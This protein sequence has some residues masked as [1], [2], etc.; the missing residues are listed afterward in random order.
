[1]A[2]LIRGGTV[3][4]DGRSM[5]CDVRM[6]NSLITQVGEELPEAGCMVV[7]AQ[8][9]LVFPGFID[10]HTHLDM[11]T[12]A[13][14]TADDFGTGSRA[15]L[16]GGTTTI[17]DFATQEKDGDLIQ[18]LTKWHAKADGVSS[19]DYA[20][21]MAI[22]D[23][24]AQV[25]SQIAR[26]PRHGVTSFKL[27]MAYDNLRI[28][29]AELYQVLDE[30]KSIGGIAGAHCENG[31][32]VN[33][34]TAKLWEAG[35]LSPA[36]HP[37]SRPDVVEAEAVW[38][39]LHIARLADVPVHI[40]HLSTSEAL[41]AVR[42]AR[43]CGQK[44]Y[45]ETCP[46]YLLLDDSRYRLPGFEGAKYVCSPPLRGE[47][48]I[49]A[50]WEALGTGEIQSVS[51][52][53]CSFFFKGQKELGLHDFSKI[54]GGLPG[55]EHR[56]A[57]IYTYGVRTGRITP[58]QMAALLSGNAARLFGMYP[59]KGAVRPGSD[60]DLVIWDPHASGVIR[61]AEQQQQTDYTPYEGMSVTGAPRM[62][63]LRGRKAVEN[64]RLL[65]EKQGKYIFRQK[66]NGIL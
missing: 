54:P 40:V 14:R 35:C 16:T 46:H 29:D 23:W 36:F 17:I 47:K 52:D 27:Y 56:P 63:F 45:V 32:L 58:G 60:A 26:M 24:N 66:H 18:A 20:F 30:V 10:A 1:M 59:Q 34:L 5:R 25:R 7:D 21:H 13:T 53:H 39:F 28:N 61:A 8:G 55:I 9:C 3:V 44:V 2:V 43:K 4:D 15:A 22:T 19:C 6:E 31:D 33:V 51:T 42:A 41:E 38:R 48:D 62:V 50:L 11:D 37:A 65:L 64:G 12:G 49:A 57:L